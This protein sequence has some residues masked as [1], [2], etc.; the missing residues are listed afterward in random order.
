MKD[1]FKK[2]AAFFKAADKQLH[3]LA[4]YAIA[5]TVLVGLLPFIH[6]WF[7]GWWCFSLAIVAA[8]IAGAL[9]EWY[10]YKHPNKHDFEWQDIVADVL[11]IVAAIGA[12]LFYLLK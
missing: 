6:E 10:D 8:A 3:I 9:K 4:S 1:F 2:I 7:N 11:G 5:L 12:M